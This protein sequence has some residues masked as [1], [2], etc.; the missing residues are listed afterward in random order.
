[1][2]KVLI[3]GGSG[4]LGTHIREGLAELNIP[5][6]ILTRTPA[7]PGSEFFW[8][9][10]KGEIDLNAFN[11]VN[12]ILHLSGAGI[13]DKAWTEG[14]KKV[15]V[16][17]RVSSASLIYES[18]KKLPDHQVKTFIGASAVGYYGDTGSEW[19][20][21]NSP[22]SDEFL[23]RTCKAWEASSLQFE[24][25]NIDVA[26]L[27]I[28][29]VLTLEGGLLPAVATP[30]KF[31]AGAPLGNGKQYMSWIH[32]DDLVR[33]FIRA[34]QTDMKGIYNAIAPNPVTHDEFMK[35]LASVLHRPVWPIHVPA[36]VL[37]LVLGEKSALVLQG[38]RIASEKISHSGFQ[39]KFRKLRE[40]LLDLYK[41]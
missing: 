20:D 37:K 16:D 6:A 7:D 30:M 38:Q 8:D 31:F 4:M 27:R 33:I 40:A 26:I 1:M 41:H 12:T 9:I 5:S 39:F 34:I 17:S 2:K 14:R 28:G 36:F 3:S 24:S 11:G 25:L 19:V 29:L 18:L 22:G 23:G 13:A 15:I 21:E 10:R 32:V 35:T